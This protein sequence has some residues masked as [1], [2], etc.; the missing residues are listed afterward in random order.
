MVVSIPDTIVT[1]S[2]NIRIPVYITGPDKLAAVEMII[3]YDQSIVKL[4]SIESTEMTG[5]NITNYINLDG[6]IK[7]VWFDNS[8][9][10]FVPVGPV[11]TLVFENVANTGMTS[12]LLSNIVL[13]NSDIIDV[14][15]LFSDGRLTFTISSTENVFGVNIKSTH[16]PIHLQIY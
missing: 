10:G 12:L 9:A 14:D 16:T 4:T 5:W 8:L 15:Y 7:V 1:P 11:M 3:N 6:A 13:L 2:N